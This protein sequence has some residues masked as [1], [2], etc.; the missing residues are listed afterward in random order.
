[1]NNL[2]N[3]IFLPPL[4]FAVTMSREVSCWSFPQRVTVALT[5]SPLIMVEATFL[6]SQDYI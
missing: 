3:V 1:M 4:S 2:F 5:S 6:Q